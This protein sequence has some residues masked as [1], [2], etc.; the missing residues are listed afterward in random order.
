MDFVAL[1]PYGK[2]VCCSGEETCFGDTEEET[3][4]DESMIGGHCTHQSHNRTPGKNKDGDPDRRADQLKHDIAGYLEK[5][6]G[7]EEDSQCYI[8]T[9]T[10]KV[11]VFFHAG[12]FSISD[13]ASIDV[14]NTETVLTTIQCGPRFEGYVQIQNREQRDQ[15]EIDFF[16]DASLLK[17]REFGDYLVCRIA[18][19]N[20]AET[21]FTLNFGRWGDSCL[22]LLATIAILKLFVTVVLF[23]RHRG[24]WW[25]SKAQ[26]T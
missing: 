21:F 25:H 3:G 14:G 10:D 9:L 23:G 18:S 17:F 20:S 2:K 26:G 16:D 11:E 13:V 15:A 6:I 8:V 19:V 22:P 1:I 5:C 4:N 24:Q 12:D 7:N